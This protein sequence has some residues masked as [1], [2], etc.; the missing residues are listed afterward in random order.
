MDCFCLSEFWLKHA[1]TQDPRM[2]WTEFDMRFMMQHGLDPSGKVEYELR[3][4]FRPLRWLPQSTEVVILVTNSEQTTQCQELACHNLATAL[5]KSMRKFK[6]YPNDKEVAWINLKREAACL[7]HDLRKHV[8]KS[9]WESFK[10]DSLA[11]FS[12]KINACLETRPELLR[13]INLDGYKIDPKLDW[14]MR[15]VWPIQ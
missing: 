8:L 12:R 6:G 3:Q 1:T 5:A 9:L 2:R 14:M 11:E 7:E 13:K 15:V 4:T 10:T